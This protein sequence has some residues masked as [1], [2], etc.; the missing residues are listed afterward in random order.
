M[1]LE[2]IGPKPSVDQHGVYFDKSEPDRYIFL[3]AILELLATLQK[4]FNHTIDLTQTA[5]KTIEHNQILSLVESYCHD[6][7]AIIQKREKKTA[8]LIEKLKA[9]VQ[10][11]TNLDDDEK[12]AWLGNIDIMTEYYKQFVENELVFECLLEALAQLIYTKKIDQIDFY[13]GKNYGFVFSYLQE[14][15]SN[16]KPPFD[17]KLDIEVRDRKTIGHLKISFP[18]QLS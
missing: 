7:E 5:I 1:K 13:L 2:Y 6:I 11:N 14:T 9:D 8:E 15:L 4:N 16:H 10:T 18:K 3:V 17:A 12:S